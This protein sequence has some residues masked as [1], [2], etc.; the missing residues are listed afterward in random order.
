MGRKAVHS[1]EPFKE[2]EVGGGGGTQM[3]WRSLMELPEEGRH[4]FIVPARICSSVHLAYACRLW[5]LIVDFACSNRLLLAYLQA[6]N[7]Q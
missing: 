5:I 7:H 1:D 6:F 2:V 4:L 3:N